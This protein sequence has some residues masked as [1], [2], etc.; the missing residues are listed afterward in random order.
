MK[1]TAVFSFGRFNPP[2]SGHEKLIDKASAVAKKENADFMVFPSHSQNPKK[3]PL[4]HKDKVNFMRKMFPRYKGNIMSDNMA[5]NAF[6]IVS[7][8]YDKGYKRC[9]MVVGGDRVAEFKKTLNMYNGVKGKHGFYDFENGIEIVSAGERD[10]DAEGVAGMSA[11]KMRAAAAAND[12]D[13]FKNGLPSGYKEGEKLFD[14]IRKGMNLSEEMMEFLESCQDE[15]VDFMQKDIIESLDIMGD[16]EITIYLL[17][18]VRQDSDIKDK[19]GSQPAKYYASDADG[20]KMSKSTKDKRAAHFKKNKKGPAPG[21]KGSKTKESEHTKKYRQMFGEGKNLAQQ[22]AIAIAK[23]NSDKYDKDGKK[24]K[25]E[26]GGCWD[27][28]TPVGMKKKGNRMVPNCVPEEVIDEDLG[29][30]PDMATIVAFA[31]A[32]KMTFGAA[33]MLWATAKGAMKIKRWANKNGNKLRDKV[34]SKPNFTQFE[35]TLLDEISKKKKDRYKDQAQKELPNVSRYADN[36]TDASKADPLN[37]M[38]KSRGDKYKKKA[39][40][41][42]KGI[43]RANESVQN[44]LIGLDQIKKFESVVDKLFAKY[45]ID[46]NFTRHFGDRMDDSRNNPSITLKELAEFIKKMYKRQGKSIKGVAG[47]EAVL[48]DIQ[49]NLNIPVAVTY[50]S[51]NDEFDVVLK[52]IMRKKNFTSPDKVIKYEDRDYKKERE[53]YLGTPEQMERN[54]ARKRARRLAVKTG[55]AKEGDGRDIHHKDGNPLNNDTK[56]LSSVTQ[57]Y[58]RSEPRKR[59]K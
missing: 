27:G 44:G 10:P 2:T 59:N 1:D 42:M 55:I 16:G 51:K 12:Y 41:R 46:F 47:A 14:A 56:N 54:A 50:D 35:S 33:K 19:N 29:A 23:K 11:S 53:N 25:K 37:T 26:A 21:D 24:V 8:L 31:V 48:K 15:L 52:T 20:D 17:N 49:S 6:N 4:S 58:N 43:V 18:E 3:D 39:L 22:A 34:N 30:M 40:N 36:Y 45:N 5:R 28:Y 32:A 13:S 7:V 9:I 38:Y 57:K